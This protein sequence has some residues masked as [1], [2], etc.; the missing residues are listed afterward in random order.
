M[1]KPSLFIIA[2]L[3]SVSF[4]CCGGSKKNNSTDRSVNIDSITVVTAEPEEVIEA[5]PDT[6]Y[7]SSSMIRHT[8][9]ILDTVTAP[10]ISD[11]TDK[12]ANAPGVFSFRGNISRNADYAGR[13]TGTPDT[14][15]VDWEFNTAMTPPDTNTTRW[16]GGSGW[17]GQP[18]YVNWPDSIVVRFKASDVVN[19]NFA[20]QEIIVGSLC[21]MLY[22]IDFNTGKPSRQAIDVGNPIKGSVSLDPT[23]NGNLYVGQGVPVKRPFGH[24]VV[25]LD[26]GKISKLVPEDRKAQRRWGAF[27]SS[28]LRV[29][30][31]LFWPGENG[32]LY[33]YIC[34]DGDIIPH[35]T[36]RYTRNGVAPGMEASISVYRNYGYTA[37]NHGTIVCTNLDTMQPV[38]CFDNGDDTDAT[39]VVCEE[40]GKPFVYIGNEVDRKPNGPAYFRKLDALNGNLIWEAS[41]PALRADI[42]EKHFDG[43]YYASPLPGIGNC[44]ELI[45]SNCVANTKNQNGDFV[46]INR[47]TGEIVY[48][49]K[50][51]HYAWSSPVGFLNENDEM[52]IF[53][54][55]TQGNAYLI[56]GID[57]KLLCRK[58]VGNNFESSPAVTGNQVVVGSRG[59]SIYKMS[60]K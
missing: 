40:D 39:V 44:K 42:G 23:L 60:I 28:P 41:S 59:N 55:D 35:S 15:I 45:F 31:F 58:N 32:T 16:G 6:A 36:M 24:M 38:W 21:H 52:F 4:T 12:Y 8:V 7:I 13:V 51:S 2:A 29:D 34:A 56:N 37:D 43:G 54:G 22:F 27:D 25:D 14:I 11:Y 50:L 1:R 30:K 19:D 18:V 3:L 9:E 57:G 49:V 46:A 47:K 10:E 5:L 33:K 48:R 17:T 26:K 20:N 53:T